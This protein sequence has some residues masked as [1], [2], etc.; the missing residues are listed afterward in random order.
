M[1]SPKFALLMLLCLSLQISMTRA[2]EKLL[3]GP[4]PAIVSLRGVNFE[5][6]VSARLAADT[7][8]AALNLD[9]TVDL[10]VE[11]DRISDAL[12]KLAANVLPFTYQKE[13]CAITVTKVEN[14]RLSSKQY[15]ARLAGTLFL[16]SEDCTIPSKVAF[17]IP[18]IAERFDKSNLQLRIPRDPTV[19][20]SLLWRI[21]AFLLVGDLRKIVRKEL[22]D[23]LSANAK[24]TISPREGMQAAFQGANFNTENGSLVF[25]VVGDVHFTWTGLHKVLEELNAAPVLRLN[26]DK[27][28]P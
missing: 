28:V 12:Q 9:G 16:R 21:G 22:Q 1:S 3:L 10:A 18:F 13:D 7:K 8:G 6:T 15:E 2:Q 24:L 23:F 26:L 20:V 4:V 14:I 25:H 5:G 27:P 11:P 19:D 17:E